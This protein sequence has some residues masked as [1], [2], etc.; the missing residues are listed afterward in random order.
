MS[1]KKWF[2]KKRRKEFPAENPIQPNIY[3]DNPAFKRELRQAIIAKSAY[4]SVQLGGKQ[5][6]SFHMLREDGQKLLD[7]CERLGYAESW[8]YINDNFP[9]TSALFD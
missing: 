2:P 8:Q 4:V 1:E 6:G 3:L 9:D 7:C 5:V